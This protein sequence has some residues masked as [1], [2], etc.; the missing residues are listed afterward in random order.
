MMVFVDILCV[1]SVAECVQRLAA[2]TDG[3]L[4]HGFN[5][6]LGQLAQQA[7]HLS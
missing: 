2:F 1:C 5:S 4:G 6:D 7:I 3:P